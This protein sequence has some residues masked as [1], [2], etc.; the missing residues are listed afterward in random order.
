[1][2]FRAGWTF[3][4][5]GFSSW[6][7]FRPGSVFELV[8]LSSWLGTFKFKSPDIVYL[9]FRAG[10][11]SDFSTMINVHVLVDLLNLVS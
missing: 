8:G 6:I 10:W 7:G 4:L 1:M 5:A 3:E 11:V 2:D 9:D